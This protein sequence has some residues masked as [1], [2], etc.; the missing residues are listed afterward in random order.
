[1]QRRDG[2]TNRERTGHSWSLVGAQ[3]RPLALRVSLADR[4]DFMCTERCSRA[5]MLI[6]A[7]TA[8]VALGA[9]RLRFD[10]IVPAHEEEQGILATVRSVSSVAYPA[11]LRRVIV[12]ADNCTD[13]T[14]R[15]A[16][17]AGAVVWERND[18]TRR[19]KGHAL[20]FGFARSVADGFADAVVVVDAD[21]IVSRNLLE[22]IAARIDRGAAVVQ[23]Y[24]GVRNPLASWRTRL[25]A[26]AFAMFHG[27]RSSAR[28]RLGL[29]VGLR[30]NGMSFTIAA[31]REV[32]YD[33]FS[34]VEDV[35]YGLRLGHRG[36]RVQY[37][38]EAQVLG[39]MV[40]GRV[41]SA[42][43]RRRWEGGRAALARAHA[44]PT[45]RAAVA[46]RDP[47]LFDLAVDLVLPPLAY[48]S[49]FVAWGLAVSVSLSYGA[50][51]MLASTGMYGAS[52]LAIAIHV[53]RGWWI[54][55]MGWRGLEALALA[56]VFLFL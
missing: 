53:G 16:S 20:A 54:S 23:A 51:R 6:F 41:G 3:I 56:P 9:P 42:A 50:G 33:A 28:E 38:A 17:E 10:I 22:A 24:Y 46:R 40:A 43:Q 21:S 47:I 27:V 2:K 5:M 13:A 55:G 32:P 4:H 8:L 34:V 37:A 14:A 36:Y 35:E 1:V 48:V 7:E 29:S 30:G 52:A 39:D 31:L 15:V 26:I 45:L 25:L 11:P 49:A 12:V 44:F 18:P 19:G